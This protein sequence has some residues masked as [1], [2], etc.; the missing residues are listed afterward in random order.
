MNARV[1]VVGLGPIGLEM[2]RALDG[3]KTVEV[4]GAADPA[5]AGADLGE[6]AGLGRRGLLVAPSASAAYAS[7]RGNV[8]LLCTT[9][10]VGDIAPQVE[11]AVRAGYRVVST[12]EELA[13]PARIDAAWGRR[14]DELCQK[15]GVAVLGTGVNPGFVMDR[16]PLALAA[17]CARVDRVR[18][19]RVV[20]AAR[21]RG[22]LRKKVG[23]G[24]TVEEFQAGVA[25][26]R[27][28]HVGL[29][30]SVA[31]VAAGLHFA[32][33]EVREN[34]EPVVTSPAHPREGIEPGQVAGVH[35]VAI[36]LLRGEA[37]ITLDLEMSVAAPNPRDRIQIA[38]DPPLD[39]LIQGG[40]Q[41][42]RGTVGA[43]VNAIPH[44]LAARPGLL[45]I[46]D[47]PL[48]GTVP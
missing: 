27:L 6:L 45:T 16:L 2:V 33:D 20:D 11:E 29:A 35:Q 4:V 42:D 47:L 3:R 38:G 28:G 9:S 40:T 25:A 31:L 8:A 13:F 36:G 7:A 21:R 23:A 30:E 32:L 46:A 26:G 15:S 5:F 14:I 24:L 10:R 48:L 44:V 1:V 19:W 34:V 22:P 37:V 12:C 17:A 18:V 43:V 39:V 41:G